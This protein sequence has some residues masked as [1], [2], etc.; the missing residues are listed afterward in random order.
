MKK[1]SILVLLLT[2]YITAIAQTVAYKPFAA[3]YRDQGTSWDWTELSIDYDEMPTIKIT[4][5]KS[6]DVC[7]RIDRIKI[8]NKFND[9]FRFPYKG[10]FSETG[11]LYEVI[12]NKNKKGK[13]L[14]DF[15]NYDDGY[16]DLIFKY[17]NIEYA[18]RILKN[19]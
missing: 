11:I 15:A 18:Y 9:D 12:D 5:N 1:L 8:D 7:S 10:T 13:V 17:N 19:Q 4:Y 2:V 14:F 16:F 6:E 3:Y